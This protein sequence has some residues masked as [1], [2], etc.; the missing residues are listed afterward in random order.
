MRVVIIHSFNLG[1]S[2]V[3]GL[4]AHGGYT[5]CALAAISI[6]KKVEM[7]DIDLLCNW[8]VRRQMSFEGGFNGRINKLV[9]N[10]SW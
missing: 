1:M 5:F 7:I 6:L 8:F 4:E 2:S 3:P 9:G 10:L